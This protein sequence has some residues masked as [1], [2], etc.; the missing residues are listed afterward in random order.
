M[1]DRRSLVA[2]V[3]PPSPPAD[4]IE[5][6]QGRKFVFGETAT[7]SRAAE[8]P[9]VLVSTRIRSDLARALKRASL[10]RQLE[11][12]EPNTL[13]DILEEAVEPWLR[14]HGHLA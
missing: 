7:A 13:Q 6:A 12:V 11:G 4:P 9:R 10:Q 14:N 3:R 2:G 1:T 5:E 8:E